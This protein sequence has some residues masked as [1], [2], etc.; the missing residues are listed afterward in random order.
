[1]KFDNG[2]LFNMAFTPRGIRFIFG[3]AANFKSSA[4]GTL[5]VLIL[6]LLVMFIHPNSWA[7]QQ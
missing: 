4:K 7:G 1:M 6:V 3:V 2:V 5:I